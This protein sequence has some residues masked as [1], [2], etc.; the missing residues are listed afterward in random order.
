MKA[1]ARQEVSRHRTGREAMALRG[2]R[3]GEL[4]AYFVN[5][6]LPN[7]VF[8]EFAVVCRPVQTNTAH[9]NKLGRRVFL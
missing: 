8:E 9:K 4:I 2:S 3:V 7:L 1:V 5:D 6:F